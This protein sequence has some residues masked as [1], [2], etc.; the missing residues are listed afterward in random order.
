MMQQLNFSLIL[1][2]FILVILWKPGDY[3]AQNATELTVHSAI[4]VCYASS[5]LHQLAS[6]KDE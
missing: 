6:T 4:Q 5:R 1:H 3:V 2:I